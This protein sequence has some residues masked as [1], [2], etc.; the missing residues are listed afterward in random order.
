M[1]RDCTN[2]PSKLHALPFWTTPPLL[3]AGL[4]S[5]PSLWRLITSLHRL[6]TL[7][8]LFKA[9]FICRAITHV[10][11]KAGIKRYT[12]TPKALETRASI[13]G[14]DVQ[15]FGLLRLLNKHYLLWLLMFEVYT[16]SY[17]AALM[18]VALWRQRATG[19]STYLNLPVDSKKECS[20]G[21]SEAPHLAKD[22][23]RVPKEVC[24][25]SWLHCCDC[26]LVCWRWDISPAGG[27]HY[28]MH[29]NECFYARC[30]HAFHRHHVLH[31]GMSSRFERGC[32]TWTS[33]CGRPVPAA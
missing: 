7:S 4:K 17:E 8:P 14:H 16:I 22:I 32:L 13:E 12:C 2:H 27:A 23:L 20:C 19:I 11:C 33:S 6:T 10:C 28:L 3:N 18:P 29:S 30:S 5:T 1:S 24:K 25:R 9:P 21:M 31:I 15:T 26:V